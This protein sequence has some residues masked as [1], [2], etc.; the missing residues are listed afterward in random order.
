MAQEAL[1]D[2]LAEER[3]SLV[4]TATRTLQSASAAPAAITVIHG[5]TLRTQGFRTVAEALRFV[6]GIYVVDDQSFHQVGIRGVFS[7]LEVANDTIKV[8]INGQP[9]AFRPNSS[10]YLGRS[11]VPLTAVERIEIVRGP[12][13]ALYGA[14]AFLGVINVI[15]KD[16]PF[17]DELRSS[18]EFV[19][20]G[21]V[22]PGDDANATGGNGFD[23]RVFDI[24]ASYVLRGASETLISFSYG[25]SN[26]S[27]LRLPEL[28]SVQTQ[29]DLNGDLTQPV[30]D[31]SR[32]G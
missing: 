21:G 22:R 8:M 20:R 23:P 6:S 10:S 3:K 1:F 7:G 13:S 24:D 25:Q 31:L 27:D 30:Q 19:L 2:Y 9:I 12:A 18:G 32:L 5:D 15:T 16:S 28:E 11:F 17:S 29:P 14:N 4:V 26:N